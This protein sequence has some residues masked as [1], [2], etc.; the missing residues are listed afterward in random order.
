MRIDPNAIHQC[1][2]NLVSN[3]IDACQD[4]LE[5]EKKVVIRTLDG[6]GMAVRYEVAD[7]GHGIAPEILTRIFNSFFTTKGSR[8]TGIGLM[9]TKKL[10]KE[11][12]GAIMAN[13]GIGQGATFTITIPTAHVTT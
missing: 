4:R 10:V 7:T 2:T 3:A 9:A 6:G 12:G 13:S 1:L 11:M 8:G 5:G